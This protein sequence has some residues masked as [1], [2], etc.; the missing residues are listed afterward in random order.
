MSV[1]PVSVAIA[2]YNSAAYL[3]ETLDSVLQQTLRPAE[4]V[5]VDD[6]S[7]DETSQVVAR[8]AGL[9]NVQFHQLP[10][11]G[12]GGA[13]AAVIARASQPLI[14]LLDADDLWAPDKLA[15]QVPVMLER[16]HVG[17]M[18]CRRWWIDPVGHRLDKREG[19]LRRGNVLAEMF[20]DNFVCYSSAIVRRE[21]FDQAGSFDSELPSAVDYD[22]WLR[23]ARDSQFDYID[24][25]LV[26][27]RTGHANISRRA[28]ARLRVA[29]GIMQ[30]F[31]ANNP[32]ALSSSFVR[33]CLAETYANLGLHL[34]D[35]NRMRATAAYAQSCWL[36]PWQASTYRQWVSCYVPE[37]VRQIVRRMRGQPA[38]WQRTPAAE[39]AS[40]AK[41]EA[42]V[43][44]P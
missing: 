2:T 28:A 41:P 36:D 24:E 31:V 6:G 40:S 33:Q 27:Y 14:A 7:T 42:T 26:A 9:A 29:L 32:A 19:E 8:Y 20:R 21:V 13:K 15:R 12:V 22:F 16:P 35:E 10:H 1:A 3:P 11:Q 38:K 25:S 37:H 30:R 4:I 17:V 23:A 39:S 18:Y 44:I 34:R 43:P 5:I